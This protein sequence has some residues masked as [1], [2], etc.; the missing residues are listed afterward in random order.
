MTCASRYADALPANTRLPLSVACPECGAAQGEAC[1]E[2]PSQLVP[3]ER[4]QHEQRE[5]DKWWR[6][7][8]LWKALAKRL[9]GERVEALRLM[10]IAGDAMAKAVR[11][12]DE[13]LAE[14][15][16]VRAVAEEAIRGL[17]LRGRPRMAA[18]LRDKLSGTGG[19]S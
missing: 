12:R 11:E 1:R 8:R 19:G 9:R 4:L 6:R 7:A 17:E 13:A 15:E 2:R 18:T 5:G 3:R 16:W 14:L 10:Y